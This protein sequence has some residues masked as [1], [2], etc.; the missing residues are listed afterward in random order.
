VR[1]RRCDNEDCLNGWI[2]VTDEWAVEMSEGDPLKFATYRNS[3]V[4]CSVDLP[5]TFDRWMRGEYEPSYSIGSPRKRK[6]DEPAP[7]PA[8]TREAPF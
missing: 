3:V 7:P 6:R 1:A 4:P 2:P 5:E 8:I